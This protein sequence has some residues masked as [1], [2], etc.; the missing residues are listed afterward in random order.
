MII[1]S[2]TSDF[3]SIRFSRSEPQLLGATARYVKSDP[4]LST[5]MGRLELT[6]LIGGGGTS[7]TY[8]ARLDGSNELFAVKIA[9]GH[10]VSL[11]QANAL[12][13]REGIA[14]EQLD[15]PNI[16]R[17][18]D[19]GVMDDHNF[20]VMEYLE[21]NNL[22]VLLEQ[23]SR[24]SALRPVM[25]ALCS[26]LSVV[27]A[28]EI[29]HGDVNPGNVFILNKPKPGGP[30]L[31]LLD[32][33]LVRFYDEKIIPVPFPSTHLGIGTPQFMSVDALLG[34]PID[35]QADLHGLGAILYLA[36]TGKYPFEGKVY[37]DYV[38]AQYDFQLHGLTSSTIGLS[39][40][41]QSIIFRLLTLDRREHYPSAAG[42]AT[43]LSHAD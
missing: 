33:G 37:F 39:E 34:N 14:L 43:A 8:K 25:L 31:K 21:G 24:Y 3:Q 16:V 26:A 30:L 36:L 1:M 6:D 2:P 7:D 20:L 13:V 27:H 32:F 9:R 40:E 19:S 35:S 15:H 29:V 22:D 17:C 5:R 18:F 10:K 42:L 12:I 38:L 11:E 28:V 4:L 41:L 23:F